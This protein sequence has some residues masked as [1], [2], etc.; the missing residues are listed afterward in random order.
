MREI[1][2]SGTKTRDCQCAACFQVPRGLHPDITIV[3]SAKLI[4]VDEIRALT[5]EAAICPAASRFKA[6]IIDGADR[7]TTEAADA[8]LKT[9]E[10]PPKT[11]RF[12]LLAVDAVRVPV[13]IRSR[14]GVVV[15]RPLPEAFVLSIVQRLEPDPAKALVYSRMGMGSAGQ[16]V[17]L[18]GAGRL[19]LRDQVLRTLHASVS[20]DLPAVFSLV[21]AMKNDLELAMV[22]TEQ[23][24]HDVLISGHDPKRVVNV[25]IVETIK[26]LGMKAPASAWLTLADRLSE[27]RSASRVSLNLSFHLKTS[28]AEMAV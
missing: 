9:L 26:T 11:V 5:A 15:Y 8:L 28:L 12:F 16:A 14:C 4:Q 7:F 18:C 27:L 13:T 21:D 2:C 10:E 20:R 6:L 3:T 17:D 24:I 22:M 23:A 25:D 19:A 1:L